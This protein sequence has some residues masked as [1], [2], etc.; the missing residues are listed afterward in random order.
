MINQNLSCIFI[1][2][3]FVL[4]DKDSEI[5]SETFRYNR[6][7]LLNDKSLINDLANEDFSD[8]LHIIDLQSRSDETV[9][10][11][12]PTIAEVLGIIPE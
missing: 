6:N 3:I 1:I 11:S 2:V 7:N 8:L 9:K 5:E 4:L 10:I 12:Y